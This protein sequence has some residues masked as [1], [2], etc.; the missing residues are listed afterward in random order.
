M[1]L[2]LALKDVKRLEVESEGGITL[3]YGIFWHIR[4]ARQ[5]DRAA[6]I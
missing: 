6:E 3:P 5:V 2:Y 1:N 4:G